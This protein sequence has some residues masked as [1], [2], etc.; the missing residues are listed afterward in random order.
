MWLGSCAV[1]EWDYLW[2]RGLG[3]SQPWFYTQ[4]CGV[5]VVRTEVSCYKG[6]RSGVDFKVTTYRLKGSTQSKL[7]LHKFH[8]IIPIKI[9]RDL[10]FVTL[11]LC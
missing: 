4:A 8:S 6:G 10:S 11:L 9:S 5:R 3:K 1:L 2:L 7:L